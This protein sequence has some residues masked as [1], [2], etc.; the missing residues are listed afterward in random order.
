[1]EVQK[2]IS[3]RGILLLSTLLAWS[4]AGAQSWT[5]KAD[6]SGTG[7]NSAAHFVLGGKAYF[8]GGVN[9][10]NY[11]KEV[12]EYDPQGNSWTQKKD[13]PGAGRAEAAA[14]LRINGLVADRTALAKLE[15]S[16]LRAEAEIAKAKFNRVKTK[17]QQLNQSQSAIQT[18]AR[19]VEITYAQAGLTR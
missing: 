4:S 11:M 7:R 14:F 3:K 9:A 10:G 18:Q 16:D 12:W 19:M 17:L 5:E 8:V 2:T 13:F 15:S 6:I 1:M